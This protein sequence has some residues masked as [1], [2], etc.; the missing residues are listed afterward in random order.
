MIELVIGLG[1][2]ITFGMYLSSQIEKHI[3]RR[4][5]SKRRVDEFFLKD[6]INITEDITH[7]YT[8]I[9]KEEDVN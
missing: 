1:I 6:D 9:K 4:C 8:H 7:Y 3:D 5:K 2:G